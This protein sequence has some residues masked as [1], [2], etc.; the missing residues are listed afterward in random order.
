MSLITTRKRLA[1][2]TLAAIAVG[3]LAS[4]ATLTPSAT[5]AAS[6]TCDVG[7]LQLWKTDAETGTY[8]SG[9]VYDV[10]T[11]GNVYVLPGNALDQRDAF[12]N[13]FLNYMETQAPGGT[14]DA[15]AIGTAFAAASQE[16]LGTIKASYPPNATT[17]ASKAVWQADSQGIV[18][19]FRD[20]VQTR[21]TA[22]EA[23][24][25]AYA[26]FVGV[27]PRFDA[28]ISEAVNE[29]QAVLNATDAALVEPDL[30]TFVAQ[31]D[32]L[33]AASNWHYGLNITPSVEL[34]DR[35]V[36]NMPTGSMAPVFNDANAYAAGVIG[37]TQATSVTTAPMGGYNGANATTFGVKPAYNDEGTRG[38]LTCSQMTVDLT[39][40]TAPNGYIL[41]TTTYPAAL[42]PVA[43]GT[44]GA[45]EIY[46]SNLPANGD[47]DPTP[48]I[49]TTTG[50]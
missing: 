38:D 20:D 4:L 47:T 18:A 48:P 30:A 46:L 27:D 41:D 44:Q 23:A 21:L 39:E 5:A 32:T 8:L 17:E 29:M 1:G 35:V 13:A 22:L 34:Q 24:Q 10:E 19:A 50:L 12:K 7:I 49:R 3:S 36:W 42:P 33:S 40:T 45:G 14:F 2:M 43:A 15:S 31:L 11:S 28:H 25:T 26:G 6:P 9:A 37:A 16:T